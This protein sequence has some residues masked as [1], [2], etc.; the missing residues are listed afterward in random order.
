M[1]SQSAQSSCLDRAEPPKDTALP[2]DRLSAAVASWQA[3]HTAHISTACTAPR[4]APD[5]T[6]PFTHPPISTPPAPSCT[7]GQLSPACRLILLWQLLLRNSGYFD[8]TTVLLPPVAPFT[9]P[10]WPDS[11]VSRRHN[12]SMA[13]SL[14]ARTKL[15]VLLFYVSSVCSIIL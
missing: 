14:K 11:D 9:A 15:L 8:H 5:W 4:V 3:K 10:H 13:R 1:D 6:S 12:V 7:H 2:V